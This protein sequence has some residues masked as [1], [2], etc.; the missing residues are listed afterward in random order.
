MYQNRNRGG[1]GGG[2]R[3]GGGGGYQQRRPQYDRKPFNRPAPL[4]EGFALYYIAVSCPE[5]INTHVKLFKDYMQ[6]QYG[7]RAAQKS[8]AHLTVVPP[9]KAEE[10]I[11]AQLAD[12]VSTYNI[13][14][15]PYDI[16][17]KNFGHFGERVIY[18]DVVPNESL[19]KIEKD[20]NAQFTEG[21]PSI[22]FRTK[23]DFNP[24]VT[25]ATRDIP[26]NRFDEAWQYFEKQQFDMSFNTTGLTLYKL[27]NFKWEAVK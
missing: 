25:I 15:V 24:H 26:E 7:C 10:D 14:V 4:P 8:E 5:E 22:I 11:E 3:Y 19:N 13:G 12:F 2:N 23:P 6:Q 27:T 20:I 9:F 16:Q 21:F 17:L 18:I 1:G